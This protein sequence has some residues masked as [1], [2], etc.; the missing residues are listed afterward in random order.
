MGTIRFNTTDAE[1]LYSFPKPETDL[2]TIVWCFTFINRTAPPSY[3]E[4][5]NCLAKGVKAGIIRVKGELLAIENDWY[6]RIHMADATADNEI[7][8]ML[9]FT[10]WL[11]ETELPALCE[12]AYSLSTSD[13][14]AV[15]D[16]IAKE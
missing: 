15:L 1:I 5:A 6:E 3:D 10:D 11:T 7:E 9:E 14:A 2:K 8:S 16:A 4:L 12:P 13:Y